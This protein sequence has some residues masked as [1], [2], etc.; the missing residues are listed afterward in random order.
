MVRSTLSGV[1]FQ[2]AADR[3]IASWKLTPRKDRTAIPR[4]MLRDTYMQA[5]NE[6][7]EGIIDV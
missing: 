6:T 7:K 1:S 4:T 5:T 2:L 3:G